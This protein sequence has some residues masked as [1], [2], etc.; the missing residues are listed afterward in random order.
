M[1]SV[2]SHPRTAQA[3][4]SPM[5]VFP[6]VGSTIRS[7]GWRSS[8]RSAVSI[9]A[10][11]GRSFAEPPGLNPSSLAATVA[12]VGERTWTSGVPMASRMDSFI[13]VQYALVVQRRAGGDSECRKVRELSADPKSVYRRT[14][15]PRKPPAARRLRLAALLGRSLRSLPCGAYFGSLGEHPAPF[16][17]GGLVPPH[18]TRPPTLANASRLLSPT[19]PAVPATRAVHVTHGCS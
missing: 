6:L 18:S 1:T 7:P 16:I 10:S 15:Q 5:P 14:G 2:R 19:H 4:A 13:D 11:A 8:S 9:M 12:P 17:P 3:M